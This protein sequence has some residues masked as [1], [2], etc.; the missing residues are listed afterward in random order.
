MRV[1]VAIVTDPC[2]GKAIVICWDCFRQTEYVLIEGTYSLADHAFR[3]CK[4]CRK[5]LKVVE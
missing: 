1:D 2:T 4:K 3:R 5:R